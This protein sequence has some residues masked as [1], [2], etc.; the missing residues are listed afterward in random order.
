MFSFFLILLYHTRRCLSTSF[1][2]VF[3]DFENFFYVSIVAAR[4]CLL[5]VFSQFFR[6]WR[7]RSTKRKEGFLALID[8]DAVKVFDIAVMKFF[9][10]VDWY[11]RQDR[12]HFAALLKFVPPNSAHH[13]FFLFLVLRFSFL[14][15]LVSLYSLFFNLSMAF[16]YQFSKQNMNKIMGCFCIL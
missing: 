9:E 7:R 3:Q 13:V 16:L 12:D 2:K 6:L 10:F 8:I 4:K 15:I 11:P 5:I 14:L 1:S